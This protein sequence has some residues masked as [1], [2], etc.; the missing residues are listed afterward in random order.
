MTSY[1]LMSLSYLTMIG[2]PLLLWIAAV[3]SGFAG[4]QTLREVLEILI[5]IGA[6]VFGVMG[7]KELYLTGRGGTKH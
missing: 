2:V 6:I 3:A 4:T 7:I 1:K 5:G